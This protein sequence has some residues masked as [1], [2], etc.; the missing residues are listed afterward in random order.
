M[1]R[2]VPLGGVANLINMDWQEAMGGGFEQYF[3]VCS[4]QQFIWLME[5]SWIP[6]QSRCQDAVAPDS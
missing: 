3:P 2:M 5:C 4:T 1:R 6:S